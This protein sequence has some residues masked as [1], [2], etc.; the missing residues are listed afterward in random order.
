MLAGLPAVQQVERADGQPGW[1]TVELAAPG[2]ANGGGPPRT[3]SLR[4]LLDAGLALR[5]FE[6]DGTRL[7]DA[8]LAMTGAV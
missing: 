2:D 8:F 7:S 1:L 3:T 5:S 4:A 6:L